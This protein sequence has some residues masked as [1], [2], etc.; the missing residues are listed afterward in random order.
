VGYD[1]TGGDR[2]RDWHER[3]SLN[4]QSAPKAYFNVFNEAHTIVYE[5]IIAGGVVGPKTVVD[6]S[7]GTHWSKHTGKRMTKK[8]SLARADSFRTGSQTATRRLAVIPKRHGAIRSELSDHI[9]P[10][11]RKPIWKAA[12]SRPI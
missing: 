10:G 7:I 5:L 12:S 9:E 2:F 6:G 1:P 3:I 4:H 8:D 11:C